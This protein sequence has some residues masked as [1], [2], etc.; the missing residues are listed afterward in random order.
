M[1]HPIVILLALVAV[2]TV[3]VH[4]LAPDSVER[5]LDPMMLTMIVLAYLMAALVMLW[6][7][8]WAMWTPLGAGL[9]A[10]MT[11]DALLYAYILLPRIDAQRPLADWWLALVRALLVVGGPM[12]LFGLWRQWR[13]EV[14]DH[15]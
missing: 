1:R 7:T 11:A 2:L 5:W 15:A 3:A 9:L 10:T 8:G 6:R 14:R 12:T 13:E 4:T